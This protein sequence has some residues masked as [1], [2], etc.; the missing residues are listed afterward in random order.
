M[1]SANICK[2]RV[3]YDK[4]QTQAVSQ[5]CCAISGV[6]Q[7]RLAKENELDIATAVVVSIISY[8]HT[9]SL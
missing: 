8:K 4:L 2:E 9:S 5:L 7:A 3:I 1:W 6:F